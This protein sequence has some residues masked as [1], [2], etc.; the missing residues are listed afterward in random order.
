MSNT[1]TGTF[2]HGIEFNGKRLKKF[3]LRELE[4]VGEMFD[5]EMESGG[6]NFQLGFS[7][8]LAA[9]QLVQVDDCKGPFS[10]EQIRNLKP[11]DFHILRKAQGKLGSEQ[12]P[13]ESNAEDSGSK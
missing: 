1:V 3:E 11:E 7:G 2:K 13:N 10:L 9:R 6:I 4:T 5:A 8:S 12:M